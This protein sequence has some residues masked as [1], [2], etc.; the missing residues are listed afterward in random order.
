MRPATRHSTSSRWKNV[1]ELQNFERNLED[2]DTKKLLVSWLYLVSWAC[3]P[4]AVLEFNIRRWVTILF[5]VRR[6]DVL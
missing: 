3:W 4:R 6:V 1:Q 5:S 2:E